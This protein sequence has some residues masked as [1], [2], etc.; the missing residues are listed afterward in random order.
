[1]SVVNIQKR[2]SEKKS[3]WMAQ[4]GAHAI[5]WWGQECALLSRIYS[6]THGFLS[7]LSILLTCNK[8][9]YYKLC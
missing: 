3:Q 9:M 6:F 1:M 5:P 2:L 8:R 7:F 4:V